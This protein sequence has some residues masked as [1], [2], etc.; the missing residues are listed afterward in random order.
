MQL[1]CCLGLPES[2]QN[3]VD[4]L[5]KVCNKFRELQYKVLLP[6]VIDIID[7]RMMEADE[8]QINIAH[9]VIC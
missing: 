8:K 7:I 1:I 9:N 2:E 5:L 3:G 4:V 6:M